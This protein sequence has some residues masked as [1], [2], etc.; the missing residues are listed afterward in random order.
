MGEDEVIHLHPGVQP[1]ILGHQAIGVFLALLQFPGSSFKDLLPIILLGIG[2]IYRISSNRTKCEFVGIP[3]E[4]LK[5]ISRDP[6]TGIDVTKREAYLSDEEFHE[7]FGMT[8]SAFYK[9]H[10]WKQKLK[11]SV[12]LF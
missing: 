2:V 7:K 3:Y 11:M 10:K 6:V 12:D 9:L 5:V 4:R 8:K 1:Q